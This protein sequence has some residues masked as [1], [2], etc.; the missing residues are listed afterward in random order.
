MASYETS[1]DIAAPVATV[2]EVTRD[3][4]AWPQWSPTMDEVRLEGGGPVRAG[5]SARVRQPRLRPARW[6]VDRA[7]ADAAFVWHTGGPG[8][9]I[10]AEHLMEQGA[11]VT[12]MLLRI[13]VAGRLAPVVWALAGRTI[14]RYLNEEAAALKARCEGATSPA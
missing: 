6:V 11:T 13:T 7:D 10:T 9:R 14:R 2:W 1:V 8:Y 4:E 5:S 12:T 3:V